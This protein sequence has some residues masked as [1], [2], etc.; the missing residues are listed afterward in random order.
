MQRGRRE[1]RNHGGG[2]G[3]LHGVGAV[4]VGEVGRADAVGADEGDD[5]GER[6][7]EAVRVAE[8]GVEEALLADERARGD[9]VQLDGG[10][11]SGGVEGFEVRV[12]RAEKNLGI[13]GGLGQA[14]TAR[15]AGVVFEAEREREF[16]GDV[17]GVD[18]LERQPIDETAE[19]E[20]ERLEGGDGVLEL[21]GG[22]KRLGRN[23]GAERARGAAGGALAEGEALG[24][25]AADE[26][27]ARK[28][29]EIAEGADAPVGE[30]GGERGRRIGGG[31]GERGEEVF[32][33]VGR[34]EED[35]RA[36][37]G[38]GAVGVC[39]GC[40]VFVFNFLLRGGWRGRGG[41]EG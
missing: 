3:E 23:D 18:Q 33:G 4:G 21:Q 17:L 14:E 37:E 31:E 36:G 10:D 35:G 24:A 40:G 39:G 7:G 20:E 5:A 8:T 2:R 12:Q 11:R 32:L 16:G 26:V 27:V 13:G 25:E 29:G 19:S 41:G 9:E 6:F 28:R 15:V 1:R 38:A 22:G 34:E 30:D